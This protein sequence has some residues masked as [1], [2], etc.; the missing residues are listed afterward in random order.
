MSPWVFLQKRL[1]RIVPLYWLLTTI[2]VVLLLVAPQLLQSTRFDLPMSIASYLFIAWP[3]PVEAAGL[4]PVMI[5]GW[6]LNYEMAFY[7]LLALGLTMKAAWRGPSVIG[8]LLVL[9]ALSPL[10]MPPIAHFYAS[11]FMARAGAWASGWRSVMHACAEAWLAHGGALFW[12][13]CG[14]LLLGGSM[15]DETR[16]GGWSCWPCRRP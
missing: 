5:P 4:K 11:P 13:G 14:L 1:A 10:P 7:L 6:T 12:T 9:A 16:M 3:N 2:M 15:I 8:V